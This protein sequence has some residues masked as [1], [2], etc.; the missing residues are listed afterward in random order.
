MA[1]SDVEMERGLVDLRTS[2]K[3]SLRPEERIECLWHI[4]NQIPPALDFWAFRWS[5]VACLS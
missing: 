3:S 2:K 1:L 5:I 4:Y